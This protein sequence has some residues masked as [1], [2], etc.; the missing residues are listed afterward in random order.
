MFS[1]SYHGKDTAPDPRSQSLSQEGT[2]Y[3]HTCSLHI[4]VF[5]LSHE[6]T[7]KVPQSTR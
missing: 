5:H 3:A 4:P 1:S 2:L 7:P 6:I